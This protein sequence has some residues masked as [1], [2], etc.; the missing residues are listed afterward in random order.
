[1]AS[2]KDFSNAPAGDSPDYYAS[3]T[4]QSQIKVQKDDASVESGVNPDT[5]DSDEQLGTPPNLLPIPRESKG[6][7]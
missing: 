6:C 3:R 4:G 1:M 5:E 7:C 2:T